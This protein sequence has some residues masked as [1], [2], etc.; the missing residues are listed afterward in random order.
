MNPIYDVFWPL[1]T[2]L[3]LTNTLIF[4]FPFTPVKVHPQVPSTQLLGVNSSQS[5]LGID[6]YD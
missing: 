1:L 5:I 2:I 6:R 3:S 4:Q